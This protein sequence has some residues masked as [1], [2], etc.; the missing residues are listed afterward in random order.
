MLQEELRE[1]ANRINQLK[2]ETQN[3]EV[4]EVRWRMPQ[5]TL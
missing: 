4:K 1:L 3:I 2:A 5:E